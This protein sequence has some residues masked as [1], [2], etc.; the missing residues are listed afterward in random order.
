MAVNGISSSSQSLIPI[1]T[2]EKYEFWSIK[3]KTL[4]KSQGVWELVEEGFVDQASSNEEVEKL[5]KIK[6]KDAKALCF[7]QQ[8]VH[9]T[10][11]SRIAA[12]TTSSQAWKI[13]KKEFQGSAKV[14]TVKL[15]TYRREFETLSMKS[16]ESIQTYLSRVSSLVN[17]MKSYGEDISEEIVVAKVLRSLTPKFEHVVVAIE[18][19][20]D[21]WVVF[22]EEDVKEA[23][24]EV[25]IEEDQMKRNKIG[26][27][28][29]ITAESQVIRK[30]IV[31][32]SRRMKI[33]KQVLQ[34]KMTMRILDSGCSNHMSEIRSLF[35]ELDESK[36]SDVRLGDNKK[37]QVEGRGTVRIRTSQG[38]AKILEDVMFVPS[39][40]HNLLSIRQL[41]VSGYSISFDDGF[42]TIRSKKSGQTIATVPMTNNKMFPLEVSM[43]EKCAMVASS[44]NDTRLWH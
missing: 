16:N 10:I 23:K 27:F 17:Q 13:L 30:L 14:I 18:E 33:T 20:H 32:K 15:Q 26:Y 3:M 34:K 44:D 19:S 38:N 11:F 35:K 37:I 25:E 6:K 43:V 36:K 29:A 24:E 8:A 1:F 22:E 31:V 41:M 9:D 5:K 7:I 28:C 39:L 2:G 40:S 4:F 12:A 21:L 42:C